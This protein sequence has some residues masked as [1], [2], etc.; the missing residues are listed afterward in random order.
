MKGKFDE[1]IQKS[2]E[3]K[4]RWMRNSSEESPTL[5]TEKQPCFF[6]AL[7]PRVSIAASRKDKR[8]MKGA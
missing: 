4:R 8:T 2:L 7:A 1:R 5:G 3:R 6:M